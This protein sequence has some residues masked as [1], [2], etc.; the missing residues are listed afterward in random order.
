MSAMAYTQV[1]ISKPREATLAPGEARGEDKPMPMKAHEIK[2]KMEEGEGEEKPLLIATFYGKEG[3]RNNSPGNTRTIVARAWG[4][5]EEYHFR[6][7]A[8]TLETNGEISSRIAPEDLSHPKETI[9]QFLRRGGQIRKVGRQ[10][11][12]PAPKAEDEE[13]WDEILQEIALPEGA[14]ATPVVLHT[15]NQKKGKEDEN[16]I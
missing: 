5:L 16:G 13:A 9:E 2:I 3:R 12:Q 1:G 14:N 4:E 11:L 8:G 15:N 10:E 6:A 7:L